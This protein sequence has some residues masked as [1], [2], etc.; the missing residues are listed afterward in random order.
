M[1]SG[2]LSPEDFRVL[3]EGYRFLRSLEVRMRLSHDASIEQFDPGGVDPEMV[4]RYRKETE[5]IR[6][7][8]LKVLGLP[9]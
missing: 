3:D 2:I 7:V 4:D 9:G 5:R 6:K 1:R 8:Y